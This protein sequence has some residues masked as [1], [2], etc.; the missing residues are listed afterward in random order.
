MKEEAKMGA[1]AVIV[2]AMAA[3]AAGQ[4]EEGGGGPRP[5]CRVNDA[6]FPCSS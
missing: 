6:Y 4:V 3:V 2:V 5:T 1:M